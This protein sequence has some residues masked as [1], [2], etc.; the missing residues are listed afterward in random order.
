[1]LLE[2]RVHRPALDE[3]HRHVVQRPGL[4]DAVHGD[5]VRVVER[6][7]EFRFASESLRRLSEVGAVRRDDFEGDRALERDL[8]ALVHDRHAA[9]A[10]L[11]LDAI[12]LAE[13]LL[14]HS[15]QRVAAR[16]RRVG[17]QVDGRR[18]G[19]RIA[20]RRCDRG[21]WVG[22]GIPAVGA[23]GCAVG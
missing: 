13:V 5:D 4:A 8:D 6:G 19:V 23:E 17:R 7:G 12:V 20:D 11:L 3:L 16:A 22:Y 18:T 14:G 21:L 10:E 1:M 15:E 2:D 9:A